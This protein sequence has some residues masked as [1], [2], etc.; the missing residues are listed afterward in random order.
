[1]NTLPFSKDDFKGSDIDSITN[2]Y[3]HLKKN[4]L[5]DYDSKFTCNLS[6]FELFNYYKDV[7]IGQVI[8]VNNN[9]A[10][11]YLTFTQ[12]AY[13]LPTASKYLSPA[14]C[15]YQTWGIAILKSNYGHI[16][17]KPETILDRI[18]DLIN[19][20]KID[21]E[22]DR[23]FSEK[24]YAV[25]TDELK[26][27]SKIDL[28][29]RNAVESIQTKDFFIEIIDNKLIIGNKKTIEVDSALAFSDF[30]NTVSKLP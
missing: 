10:T 18:H 25:T 3:D 19:P 27:K 7:N 1:M 4:F 2:I 9:I 15:E 22:D 17:M 16:L 13:K 28:S 14:T 8:S 12:V 21:F 11:F 29:F 24:F 30:L 23:K 5:I 20:T 6:E 26:A